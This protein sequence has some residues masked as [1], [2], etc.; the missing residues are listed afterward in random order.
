MYKKL[1]RSTCY[2]NQ[3]RN[4]VIQRTFTHHCLHRLIPSVSKTYL[5]YRKNWS[6]RLITTAK[7]QKKYNKSLPLQAYSGTLSRRNFRRLNVT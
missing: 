2:H 6:A 3:L 1:C 4:K 5:R 7:W